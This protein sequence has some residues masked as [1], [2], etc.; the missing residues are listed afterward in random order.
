MVFDSRLKEEKSSLA[1]HQGLFK[2]YTVYSTQNYFICRTLSI[3]MYHNLADDQPFTLH[4]S[5]FA[6]L[7][8]DTACRYVLLTY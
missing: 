3:K 5:N 6:Y 8:L 1:G 7:P 2:M 4:P